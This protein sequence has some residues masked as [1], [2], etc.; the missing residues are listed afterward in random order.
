MNR[1]LS[2]NVIITPFGNVELDL[3]GKGKGKKLVSDGESPIY[4][5]DE[6]LIFNK[7]YYGRQII[8]VSYFIFPLI[9]THEGG[10]LVTK[11]DQ[12]NPEEKV[13]ESF[14][15]T[16]FLSSNPIKNQ[17]RLLEEKTR[18]GNVKSAYEL[19]LGEQV[20]GIFSGNPNG[21]LMKSIQVGEFKVEGIEKA[22]RCF[23][24]NK[25]PPYNV[26]DYNG[27]YG[28]NGWRGF[29]Y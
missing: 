11:Y 26:N 20:Q 5:S 15:N 13:L 3:I 2:Q 1:E 23:Y 19:K 29:D 18:K 10:V 21:L 16:Y 6:N 27:N 22:M 4:V 7:Q 14:S 12:E 25:K 9:Q 8:C 24:F 17:I 28:Y